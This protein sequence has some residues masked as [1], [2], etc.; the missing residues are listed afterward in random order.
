LLFIVAKILS[1]KR[2]KPSQSM[3]SMQK[4]LSES[5]QRANGSH[6]KK[7]KVQ[8]FCTVRTNSEAEKQAMAK[9]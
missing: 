8:N 6:R 9:D 7:S 1:A 5:V 3:K 2:P 4:R